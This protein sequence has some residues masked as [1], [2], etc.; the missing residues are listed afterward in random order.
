MQI[1]TAGVVPPISIGSVT[2]PSDMSS[3]T[4]TLFRSAFRS[5]L[6]R[7]DR[8]LLLLDI[9][10]PLDLQRVHGSTGICGF[11][12]FSV[13]RTH[14]LRH[15]VIVHPVHVCSL[16][17]VMQSNIDLT[18]FSGDTIFRVRTEIKRKVEGGKIHGVPSKLKS[19]LRSISSGGEHR[20]EPDAKLTRRPGNESSRVP[21][22]SFPGPMNTG[23]HFPARR[24]SPP[25]VRFSVVL[26]KAASDRT[27][28]LSLAAIGGSHPLGA[29]RS[30]EIFPRPQETCGMPDKQRSLNK[31]IYRGAPL[32]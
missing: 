10:F 27:K 29:P 18:D 3:N 26:S 15:Q 5:W 30:R 24:E 6:F 13:E 12:G 32:L 2:S 23:R 4:I 17:L 21:E 20:S 14:A 31:K 25:E 7:P 28:I 8:S 22:D 11:T 9:H 16:F 19:L 1:P